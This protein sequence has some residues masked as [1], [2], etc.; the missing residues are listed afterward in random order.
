STTAT[1]LAVLACEDRS[2]RVRIRPPSEPAS[3]TGLRFYSWSQPRGGL[4][5]CSKGW[6]DLPAALGDAGSGYLALDVPSIPKAGPPLPFD[7]DPG[8]ASRTRRRMLAPFPRGG[9]AAIVVR[10]QENREEA[11]MAVDIFDEQW[12]ELADR[13]NDGLDIRLYWNRGDGRVKV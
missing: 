13:A 3:D 1:C 5:V 9:S 7:V 8:G 10:T 11:V 4:L 6:V 12:V 2:R